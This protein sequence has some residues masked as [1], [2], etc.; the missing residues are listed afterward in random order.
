MD[1]KE[2]TINCYEPEKNNGTS[3]LVNRSNIK[4]KVMNICQSNNL[5]K[6]LW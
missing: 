2:S 1:V 3:L 6:R 5:L 4:V